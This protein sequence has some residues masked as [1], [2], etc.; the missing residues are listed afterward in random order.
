MLVVLR[1][2]PR[3]LPAP[4]AAL[5]VVGAAFLVATPAQPWYGLLLVALSIAAARPEWSVVALAAYPLYFAS[6][7]QH[8]AVVGS[9]AYGLATVV[10]LGVATIRSAGRF[11]GRCNA[12]AD[13]GTQLVWTSWSPT[14]LR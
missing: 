14:R 3:R 7:A 4:R 12:P 6:F 11:R 1:S 5:Y 10:V 8:K 9:L 13:A 2:D